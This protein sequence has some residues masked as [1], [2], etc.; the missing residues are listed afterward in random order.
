MNI[1]D[2][3]LENIETDDSY[4][5][6]QD[7]II[8]MEYDCANTAQKKVIDKIFIALCGYSLKTM[9]ERRRANETT[10]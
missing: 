6:S 10:N 9:I 7:Y 8:S 4:N 1:R 5:K 3:V 2:Q